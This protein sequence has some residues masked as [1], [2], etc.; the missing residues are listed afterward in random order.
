MAAAFPSLDVLLDLE[1]RRSRV[2][3]A[4]LALTACAF[5]SLVS[6]LF[7]I[8]RRCW[9]V[10]CAHSH[11]G[12]KGEL[13]G[14]KVRSGD[15][16]SGVATSM[17]A[18]GFGLA[19]FKLF[20]MQAA[21]QMRAGQFAA[22]RGFACGMLLMLVQGAMLWMEEAHTLGKFVH[23]GAN[24]LDADPSSVAPAGGIPNVPLMHS[25]QAMA[26]F[27][28]LSLGCCGLIVYGFF[29][30]QKDLVSTNAYEQVPG[31]SPAPSDGPVAST[32]VGSG[33]NSRPRRGRAGETQLPETH[34]KR[35]GSKRAKRP[36]ASKSH[37]AEEDIGVF[38]DG[39]GVIGVTDL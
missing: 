14:L 17:S 37:A 32:P 16:F 23:R 1:N 29:N 2:A 10:P 36:S 27:T 12:A 13:L 24:R 25:M 28:T 5:A 22:F 4:A 33:S 7:V 15:A 35:R 19:A 18:L 9:V 34:K 31:S 21:A 26:V 20:G 38:E 30:W 8:R 3:V 6:A 39:D 11:H